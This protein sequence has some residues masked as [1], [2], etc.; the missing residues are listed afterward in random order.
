M[1][2]SQQS[3][4]I[5]AMVANDQST[6][7][8]DEVHSWS[9]DLLGAQDFYA[10][11]GVVPKGLRIREVNAIAFHILTSYDLNGGSSVKL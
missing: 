3:K 11:L 2:A 7:G 5:E 8:S 10:R 1:V 4:V 9:V 6:G